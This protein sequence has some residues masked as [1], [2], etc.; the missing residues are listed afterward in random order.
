MSNGH[1]YYHSSVDSVSQ[2]PFD[3]EALEAELNKANKSIW[4][5]LDW[6]NKPI[7][8]WILT[9]VAVGLLTYAY[10][11]YSTCRLSLDADNSRFDKLMSELKYRASLLVGFVGVLEALPLAD[12]S[13]LA[14][15]SRNPKTTSNVAAAPPKQDNQVNITRESLQILLNPDKQY[16]QLEFKSKFLD[17]IAD[18]AGRLIKKWYQV[19]EKSRNDENTIPE[20]TLSS[21]L[22]DKMNKSDL[23]IGSV[24]K[25]MRGRLMP[26]LPVTA[27][28]CK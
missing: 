14:A 16:E 7:T 26:V 22:V 21:I 24:I 1:Q 13:I 23:S 6:I 20:S 17:E 28:C 8:I 12:P 3:E 18:E 27:T 5:N 4:L 25:V 9:T 10:T 19:E 2:I 15:I 11:N